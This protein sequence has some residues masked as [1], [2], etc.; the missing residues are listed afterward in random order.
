MQTLK[1]I[2]PLVVLLTTAC[3]T[4]MFQ[5]DGSDK[6][7]AQLSM[8]PDRILLECEPL[9][10]GQAG[11]MIHVLTDQNTVATLTQSNSLA[12]T[13]CRHRILKIGTI[14]KRA[15]TVFLAGIGDYSK[16][17]KTSDAE[18]RFSNGT[19]TESGR[20]LT[21]MYV[22]NNRGEC[23]SAFDGEEKPCPRDGFPFPPKPL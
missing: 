15:S 9:E 12:A 5:V 3:A 20:D 1:L 13:S 10:N 16:I 22:W 14:I 23:F 21:F 17:N 2:S 8:T 6:S 4:S 18:Y 7:G 11:F 19:F